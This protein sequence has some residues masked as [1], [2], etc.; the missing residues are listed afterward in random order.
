MEVLVAEVGVLRP[1]RSLRRH[2]PAPRVDAVLREESVDRREIDEVAKRLRHLLAVADPERV[3][4]HALRQ[5]ESERHQH[6]R[7]DHRVEPE[8][9]LADHVIPRRPVLRALCGQHA[10]GFGKSERGRIV[11]ERID[12]HIDH[13]LGRV[14]HRDAPREVRAR[15]RHVLQPLSQATE[16]LVEPAGR[17]HEARIRREERLE[18]RLVRAQ[19]EVVVLLRGAHERT[20]A[21]RAL[22]L[23]LLRAGVGDVLLLAFVVPADELAEIDVARR[24]QPRH[25]RL[26][27]RLVA[28]LGRADEII[29]REVERPEQLAELSG[30]LVCERLRRHAAVLRALLHLSAMLVGAG[31]EEHIPSVEPHRP[32]PDVA[33][34]GRVRTPDMRAVVHVID[35]RRDVRRG[36]TGH[37]WNPTDPR[38]AASRT[39]RT[40][41]A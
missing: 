20:A 15:D 37:G 16:H 10:A 13:V 23:E 12:P 5:L 30:V 3:R 1:E 34:R 28:R 9:L 14:R 36:R 7:P 4:V 32:R 19:P 35:G 29:V 27:L 33:E 26:H 40:M 24:E 21:D 2:V 6:R 31:Q 38:A 18:L 11:E 17:A 8:D 39:L 41:P 22:V 25:E